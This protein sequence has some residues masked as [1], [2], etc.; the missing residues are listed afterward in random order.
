[1]LF[2]L[3]YLVNVELYN[4]ARNP[5]QKASPAPVVSTMSFMRR[6][7]F[8]QFKSN[9]L[10][11]TNSFFERTPKTCDSMGNTFTFRLKLLVTKMVGFGP[12]VMTTTRS[13]SMHS[14]L[15]FVLVL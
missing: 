4:R 6:V 3:T 13:P 8:E 2:Q 14:K 15:T 11:W 12:E 1:M 10:R 7:I 9:V 5:P